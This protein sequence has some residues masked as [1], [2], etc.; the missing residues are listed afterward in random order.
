MVTTPLAWESC[1]FGGLAIS[2]GGETHGFASRPYDR[3]A[4]SM[5]KGEAMRMPNIRVGVH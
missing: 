5:A 2:R 1:H 3:F 4:F